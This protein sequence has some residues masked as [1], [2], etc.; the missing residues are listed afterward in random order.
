MTNEQIEKYIAN[1]LER[2][3]REL[4][5]EGVSIY[6]LSSHDE[7]RAQFEIISYTEDD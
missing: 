5:K 2:F 1:K 6:F 4:Q 3:G 7:N